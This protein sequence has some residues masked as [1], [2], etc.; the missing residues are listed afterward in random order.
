MN[1]MNEFRELGLSE[2]TIDALRQKGFSV[3]SPIQKLAI[4]GLLS[5][6]HDLIGQA[7][8]GTGKTAAFALPILES[9]ERSKKIQALI[10]TPT[11]ELCLQ[12]TDEIQS[13]QGAN[14][15]RVASFYGG[16]SIDTQ[17]QLLKKGVDIAVGTP[18]RIMDHLRRGSIKL[19]NLAFAV[20]DEA[21]EMLDMGF[22]EDIEEILSQTNS[23]KRMLMFSAT[24]PD[25][26]RKIAEKFMVEPEIIRAEPEAVCTNLTEQFYYEVKR[27]DKFPALLRL[28]DLHP[29]MSALVFCRTKID[30]DELTEKLNAKGCN[31]EALHGDIAQAQRTRVINR[32]KAHRFRLLIATDV[33]A[34]GID[35]NNLTHVINYSIPRNAETYIHR[36]G[37]TGRAGNKGAAITFVTPGEMHRLSLIK[38]DAKAEI[39]RKELPS[40]NDIIEA[41]KQRFAEELAALIDSGRHRDCTGFAEELLS[42][43][44]NP[45]DAVAA[46]LKMK[47]K[48]EL[49]PANYPEIGAKPKVR[50]TDR[51]AWEADAG[52][53]NHQ[54][55]YIGIGKN[56]NFGAVKMLDLIWELARIKK[57]RVGKIDCFDRFSFIDMAPEDAAVFMKNA[58]AAGINVHPE[59]GGKEKKSAFPAA[60]REKKSA[61]KQE[62][63]PSRSGNHAHAAPKTAKKSA[64]RDWVNDIAQDFEVN[65]KRSGKK[66]S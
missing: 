2:K 10:L 7:Q 55:L 59:Q 64:L 41:K 28:I 44:D 37:R 11:R 34:R 21:D 66:K 45:A 3:P 32:F 56:D 53:P 24:M 19:E 27:E 25:E 1:D 42:I 13:L 38:K 22:V 17:L 29:E 33:A 46:L 51:K 40:G 49:D 14:D 4:P 62:K 60:P 50:K 30:A 43:S 58:R 8:T 47:F 9:L 57:S 48:N 16:Q 65:K 31:V 35:V 6:S 18:G 23:G 15:L 12:I 52:D 26:I 39:T 36:I 54:R 61:G 63:N 20:L 5:G